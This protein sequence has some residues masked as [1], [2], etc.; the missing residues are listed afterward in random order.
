M[1]P[2]VLLEEE[3]AVVTTGCSGLDCAVNGGGDAGL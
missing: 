3:L 1:S 2:V